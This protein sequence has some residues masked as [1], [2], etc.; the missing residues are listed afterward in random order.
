VHALDINTGAIAWDNSADTESLSSFAPSSA[1]PGVAFFGQVPTALVRSYDTENDDG[2]E[3]GAF[4]LG[5]A[6]STSAP[7]VVDGILL[8]GAGIGTR[9]STGSGPSDLTAGIASDLTALCIPG[10]AGCEMCGDATLD[11]DEECD[12]GDTT[13]FDGCSANCEVE[14][15]WN[16]LGTAQGGSISFI[17][18]GV[19]LEV[20]SF[21]GQSAADIA[22]AVA[23]EILANATLAAR[24]VVAQVIGD[25]VT[26]N[27]TIT[28]VVIT[29]PGID[30]RG[31]STQIVVP[32]FGWPWLLAAI[33]CTGLFALRRMARERA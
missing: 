15:M 14:V 31:L 1:I 16:F 8:V 12:D 7:A 4:N 24:G 20:T 19:R 23:A 11:W 26:T 21:S 2:T 5:N 3:L 13:D 25:T 10:E 30:Y 9:T 32:V 33:G 29:D 22:S 6:A 27:G 17:V 28:G 18:D